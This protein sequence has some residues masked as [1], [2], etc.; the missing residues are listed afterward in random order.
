MDIKIIILILLVI[1]TSSFI[2]KTNFQN[3]L[4]FST[5]GCS[6][7]LT[8]TKSCDGTVQKETIVDP[9]LTKSCSWVYCDSKYMYCEKNYLN[10]KVYID[11][12]CS[13]VG[14][15]TSNWNNYCVIYGYKC[16]PKEPEP[17]KPEINIQVK[18]YYSTYEQIKVNITTKLIQDGIYLVATLSNGDTKIISVYN[19]FAQVTFNSLPP[20]T[21][22]VNVRT[23]DNSISKNAYVYVYS[24]FSKLQFMGETIQ[25]YQ[26]IKLY[27]DV[28]D[29][30]GQGLSL[31]MGEV[32]LLITANDVLDNNYNDKN[33]IT[34]N[35]MGEG[36]YLINIKAY[37]PTE[38]FKVC[39]KA[40][41]I[42]YV[43]KE[44]CIELKLSSKN[45]LIDTSE[46]PKTAKVGETKTIKFYTKNPTTNEKIDV[47]YISVFVTKPNSL[48]TDK[49]Y[50]YDN[51]VK[52]ID[53]GTY[54]ITYKFSDD[55]KETETYT[56]DITANAIQTHGL[57]VSTETVKISVG[58]GDITP[59]VTTTTIST[60]GGGGFNVG[61]LIL[62]GIVGLIILGGVRK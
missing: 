30:Y 20:G 12:G 21:Y 48:A 57:G 34:L 43:P 14:V 45:V 44:S 40:T 17:T 50:L 59:V 49:F 47:D 6:E 25:D 28:K 27:L 7:Y 32:N 24:E 42:N 46:I 54:Q 38:K 39:A 1:T 23:N 29:Y 61:V 16:I 56:I 18:D 51:T 9:Y 11:G 15:I 62:I 41:K 26:N 52:R 60:G 31:L 10:N 19:N 5:I 35:E 22:I 8:P 2:V 4:T 13:N 55:L 36:K 37:K 3:N 33:I 53:K 58:L